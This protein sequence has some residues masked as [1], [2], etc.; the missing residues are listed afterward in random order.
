MST[1]QTPPAERPTTLFERMAT[2]AT[3]SVRWRVEQQVKSGLGTL[4]WLPVGDHFPSRSQAEATANRIEARTQRPT[5]VVE[6]QR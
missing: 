3:A 2:K 5:R 4:A 6:V 1:D